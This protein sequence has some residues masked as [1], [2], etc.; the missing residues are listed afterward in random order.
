MVRQFFNS[1]PTS[2]NRLFVSGAMV[3]ALAIAGCSSGGENASDT[4]TLAEAAVTQG[5]AEMATDVANNQF[6]RVVLDGIATV[7]TNDSSFTIEKPV[8]SVINTQ[9][10]HDPQYDVA[11]VAQR[12]NGADAKAINT[13]ELHAVSENIT[14]IT[15]QGGGVSEPTELTPELINQTLQVV[16]LPLDVVQGEEYMVVDVVALA[17]TDGGLPEGFDPA[18]PIAISS[19]AE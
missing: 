19:Y 12:P 18:T 3:A 2:H 8:V 17:A 5:Q 10:G 4:N 6:L 16:R 11:V 13:F 15:I 14:S 9:H 7:H 1:D